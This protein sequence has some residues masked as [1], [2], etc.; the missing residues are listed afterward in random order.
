MHA[1]STSIVKNTRQPL[2]HPF[3][4]AQTHGYVPNPEYFVTSKSQFG[5]NI[6]GR[7]TIDASHKTY[8]RV[9]EPGGFPLILFPPPLHEFVD[10][11]PCVLYHCLFYLTSPRR[12]NELVHGDIPVGQC[13]ETGLERRE[14]LD[15]VSRP[16][17]TTKTILLN[18][19]VDGRRD[20]GGMED[21]HPAPDQGMFDFRR[22]CRSA[23]SA[24]G[25]RAIRKFTVSAVPEYGQSFCLIQISFEL[26]GISALK[27]SG[28]G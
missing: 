3:S 24:T 7:G 19:G 20:Q 9:D 18:A 4:C 6:H 27:Y 21:G 25:T 12:K 23:P 13:R 10:F 28:V 26:N 16:S 1:S 15:G 5:V 11:F 8:R 2:H 17:K 14:T 22:N